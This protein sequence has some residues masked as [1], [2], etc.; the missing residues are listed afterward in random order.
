[1]CFHFRGD[2]DSRMP[3]H[4]RDKRKDM[5]TMLSHT[6]THDRPDASST[7][8]GRTSWEVPMDIRYIYHDV[9]CNDPIGQRFFL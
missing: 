4:V 5:P 8:Y 9:T 1:M 3:V 7:M 2:V 6:D